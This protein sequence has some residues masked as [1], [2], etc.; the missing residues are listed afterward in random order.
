M[1]KLSILSEPQD[2]LDEPT[3]VAKMISKIGETSTRYSGDFRNK[4]IGDQVSMKIAREII[5]VTL[6]TTI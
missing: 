1:K 6:W 2:K 4:V 3:A 5:G